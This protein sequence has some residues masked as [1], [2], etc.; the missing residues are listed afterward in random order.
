MALMLRTQLI[1]AAVCIVAILVPARA[2][3]MVRVPAGSRTVTDGITGLPLTVHTGAFEIGRNEVSQ[4]EFERV[5]KR[6][7]S[8]HNGAQRPVENV[9]FADAMEYCDRRSRLESLRPCYSAGGDW[10]RDCTGYRLPTEAEWIAAAG[11]LNDPATLGGA[12]LAPAGQNVAA[13]T[14]RAT[15]VGTRNVDVGAL[16]ATGVRDMLGNVWEW[17]WD[18]YNAETLVDS[19]YDPA[20][21]QTGRERVI[22][23]GSYLTPSKS[24]NQGFRSSLPPD[25]ASPYVGFRVA[26]TVARAQPA[27]ALKAVG[28]MSAVQ[29][30]R[31]AKPD[32]VA[33]AKT[34]LD[35]LG[36]PGVAKRRM[37]ER[38][39]ET[40]T[41][42]TWTGRL[43][44]LTAEPG[45]PWRA[46]LILPANAPPGRLPVVIVP[47]YDVDSPVGVNLG[48]RRFN[49][50]PGVRAIAHLATQRGMAALAVRWSGEN[51]GPGYLETVTALAQ[52]HPGVTGLGYWAWQAQ[53]LADWL[54]TQP[55]IDASR[56]GIAGHSLGGK[57]AVYA[58]AFEP[59]IRAVVSSEPGIS[60]AFSNYGD[61]WY[62][63]ERLALLPKGSD[64]DDLLALIAPRPFLLIGGEDS[65]GGKSLPL[66]RRAAG[67][68]A[69]LGAPG[70]LFFLNHKSGHSPSPES[71]VSAMEWLERALRE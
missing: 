56:I 17:V 35:V 60:L 70:R 54:E 36:Q 32:Q 29:A 64:Q 6:N 58:A 25:A 47:F 62:F 24:W 40:I 46:L 30:D 27:N 23:G 48:G 50:P 19:V 55:D 28:T 39:I 16:A 66:L 26:R 57:M 68:Y 34:W 59:R 38:L 33:L 65:D 71:I 67:A 2:Q 3:E 8:R 7:P 31:T 61:P 53:R 22:R 14:Q 44:E 15:S 12:H 21:P 49:N 1:R 51:D 13:L 42:P 37:T 9:S 45:F 63:G 5:M 11:A 4:A 10:N 52:R 41:E 43:L 69:G 18:R 20:G